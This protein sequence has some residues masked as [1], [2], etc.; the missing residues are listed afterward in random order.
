MITALSNYDNVDLNN[1]NDDGGNVGIE[2]EDLDRPI[3]LHGR[4][5]LLDHHHAPNTPASIEQDPDNAYAALEDPMGTN[6]D[7]T[8]PSDHQP[9]TR[10]L[11]GSPPEW[12]RRANEPRGVGLGRYH[13]R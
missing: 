7:A 11:V 6:V 5:G 13:V 8:I 4:G 2:S 3:Q 1:D 12:E 10:Q 9:P